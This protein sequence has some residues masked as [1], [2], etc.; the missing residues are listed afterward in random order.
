MRYFNNIL[1]DEKPKEERSL[2]EKRKILKK[3]PPD[4]QRRN[5]IGSLSGWRGPVLAGT[6]DP[7]RLG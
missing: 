1:E 3:Q 6:S 4:V 5:V 7:G 2:R